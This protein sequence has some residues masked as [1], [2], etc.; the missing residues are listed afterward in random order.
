MVLSKTGKV[1]STNKA[2]M[3]RRVVLITM[4]T[5]RPG[6]NVAEVTEIVMARLVTIA[7]KDKTTTTDSGM[8]IAT[9]TGDMATALTT[10][11]LPSLIAEMN[12]ATGAIMVM[13]SKAIS[14]IM[15]RTKTGP[16]TR[17]RVVTGGANL[18]AGR[19]THG[20][21]TSIMH[22]TAETKVVTKA[23]PAILATTKINIF[24]FFKLESLAGI[25]A[26]LFLLVVL[27]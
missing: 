17:A 7:T 22:H 13:D 9:K 10:V 3:V 2:V 27:I 21:T 19:K 12:M 25:P 16:G 26:R 15:I 18:A 4:S 20:M 23:V 24:K 11:P 1:D 6:T 14:G 8:L 5:A